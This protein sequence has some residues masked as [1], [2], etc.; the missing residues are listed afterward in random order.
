MWTISF[1]REMITIL[2]RFRETKHENKEQGKIQHKM[3]HMWTIS[4]TR[5]MITILGGLEKQNMRTK[6]KVRFNMK[7]LICGPSRSQAR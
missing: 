5:E 3:S 2:K 4:F 1:T 7:R 6:S